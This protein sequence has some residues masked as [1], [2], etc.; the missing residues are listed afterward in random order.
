MTNLLNETIED[1]KQNGKT[2]QDIKWIGSDD[3]LWIIPME[4]FE[5]VFNIE[6]DSGYGSQEIASDLV[7]VGEDWWME[8][9]EYDGSESWH[10]KSVPTLS[11]TPKKI[12]IIKHGMWESIIEMNGG[13][14]T[15]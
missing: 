6:Y 10:V 7:V 14:E 8:R 9:H 11:E 1:L 15:Q 12:T 4:E 3:G 2:T 13:L 5:N